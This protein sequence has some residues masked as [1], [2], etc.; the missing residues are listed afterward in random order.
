[1]AR[2]VKQVVDVNLWWS[3]R[4]FVEVPRKGCISLL[5]G[6]V[7]PQISSCAAS[8]DLERLAQA[9]T[10]T[11]WMEVA[12]ASHLG[13]IGG[14]FCLAAKAPIVLALPLPQSQTSRSG[15]KVEVFGFDVE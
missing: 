1:M 8:M 2:V 6:L 9:P 3:L 12:F 13:G 5:Q 10:G 14:W 4:F 15:K 11:C 7:T